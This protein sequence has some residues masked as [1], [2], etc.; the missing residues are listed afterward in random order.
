MSFFLTNGKHI[1]QL[2]LKL[3]VKQNVELDIIIKLNRI[4]NNKDVVR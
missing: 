2:G 4:A 1:S 3:K